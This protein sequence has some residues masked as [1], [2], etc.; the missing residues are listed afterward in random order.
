M[1]RE[2]PRNDIPIFILAVLESGPAHGYAIA[3]EIDQRCDGGIVLRDGA[4]YPAL[5][6]LEDDGLIVGEWQPQEASNGPPK[7]T[8]RLTDEGRAEAVRRIS[9]WRGYTKNVERILGGLPDAKPTS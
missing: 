1:A 3:R 6:T 2:L 8:Y 4:L 5:R 9:L 7:K